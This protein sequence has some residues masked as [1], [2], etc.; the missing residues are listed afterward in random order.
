VTF[1]TKW[2]RMRNTSSKLVVSG[3]RLTPGES[4]CRTRLLITGADP[5]YFAAFTNCFCVANSLVSTNYDRNAFQRSDR[6][7]RKPWHERSGDSTDVGGSALRGAIG[8]LT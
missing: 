5:S 8:T 4:P 7:R 1:V 6:N 3:I 2:F